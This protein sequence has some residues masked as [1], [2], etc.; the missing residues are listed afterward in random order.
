MCLNFHLLA[1]ITQEGRRG[2]VRAGVVDRF[3]VFAARRLVDGVQPQVVPRTVRVRPALRGSRLGRVE[4]GD[5]ASP[6]APSCALGD[7]S[8]EQQRRAR[9]RFAL[10]PSDVYCA[11]E[12]QDV[13]F[14][15]R[16][17]VLQE[18]GLVGAL[19]RARTLGQR[20]QCLSYLQRRL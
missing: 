18:G 5:C 1:I 6:I 11:L 14:W 2:D 17:F 16:R 4:V 15:L 9:R 3:E 7:F 8:S 12:W 13:A 10:P 19:R 20:R